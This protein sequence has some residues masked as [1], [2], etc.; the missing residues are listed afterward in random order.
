VDHFDL[1]CVGGLSSVI[2]SEIGPSVAQKDTDPEVCVILFT[3][4]TSKVL[5]FVVVSIA[6][7]VV[8]AFV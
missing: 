5:N 2:R 8:G 4:K 7:D 6:A 1:I 3:I